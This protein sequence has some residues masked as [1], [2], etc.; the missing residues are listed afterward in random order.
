MLVLLLNFFYN[1]AQTI[2]DLYAPTKRGC[3]EIEIRFKHEAI[4][5]KKY[6]CFC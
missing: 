5:P 2:M 3:K 4:R 1:V 6:V